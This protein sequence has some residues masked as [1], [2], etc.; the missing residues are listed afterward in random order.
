MRALA[1]HGKRDVR[2]DNVEDPRIE[3]PTD[4][5][6]RV[7]SSGREDGAHPGRSDAGLVEGFATHHV[8]LSDAPQAYEAFQEKRDGTF[9]V[10]FHA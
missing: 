9:K 5:I 10:V 1:W 3:E 4:A 7:I 2:V 6:I 8:S